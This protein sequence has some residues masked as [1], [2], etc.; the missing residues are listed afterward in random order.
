MFVV[1]IGPGSTANRAIQLTNLTSGSF[2]GIVG[3]SCAEGHL[4]I[5]I[6][7]SMKLNV[8]A[9]ESDHES[10]QILY[11]ASNTFHEA[12]NPVGAFKSFS[13]DRARD[14]LVFSMPV[15][16]STTES[17]PK[18]NTFLK[19]RVLSSDDRDNI[20]KRNNNN[21]SMIGTGISN[22]SMNYAGSLRYLSSRAE[23]SPTSIVEKLNFC[24]AEGANVA[25]DYSSSGTWFDYLNDYV[26]FKS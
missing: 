6:A 10:A 18:L 17:S 1:M 21:S 20:N 16:P 4:A 9:L 19:N 3:A 24:L 7:K 8:I 22:V 23:K 5:Q 11:D 14:M 15:D 12:G 26:S 25:F 13:A 2:L